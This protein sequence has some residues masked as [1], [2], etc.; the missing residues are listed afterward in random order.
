MRPL[1]LVLLAD[2]SSDRALLPI[3]VWSLREAMREARFLEPEFSVRRG[4]L[5]AAIERMMLEHRPDI[6][7]VHRDAEREA[8]ENRRAEIPYSHGVVR[9]VPVR[10]TE[11]WLLFDEAAIRMA[12]GNPNGRIRLDLPVLSRHEREPDPKAQLEALLLSA[13]QL[14]GRRRRIF[15]R[16]IGKKIQRVADYI[17]DFAPLRSQSAFTAFERDLRDSLSQALPRATD[18]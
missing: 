8:L 12:S 9:V 3:L 18:H 14:Q 11:A 4:T 7:F 2:G 16:D 5:S 15:L 17:E 1:R 6:L 10:M 13:C